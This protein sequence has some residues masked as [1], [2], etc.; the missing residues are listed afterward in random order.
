[1]IQVNS[2]QSLFKASLSKAT[3]AYGAPSN[4]ICSLH[5]L[6]PWYPTQE[7]VFYG[8]Y[9]RGERKKEL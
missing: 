2:T 3:S 4:C 6:V 1:M 5:C 8:Y 7:N 9:L